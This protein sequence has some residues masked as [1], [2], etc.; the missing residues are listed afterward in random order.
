MSK[1]KAKGG[2]GTGDGSKASKKG[3][4]FSRSSEVVKNVTEMRFNFGLKDSRSE[5]VDQTLAALF[6]T[7]SVECS[8]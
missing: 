1:L 8:R 6:D 5:R 7:L 4:D 2:G 3:Y